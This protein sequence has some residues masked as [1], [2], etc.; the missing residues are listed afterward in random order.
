MYARAMTFRGEVEEHVPLP[1]HLAPSGVSAPVGDGGLDVDRLT[2][3]FGGL[4]ALDEVSLRVAPNEVVGL[5]GPN[6]AGKTTLFN[7]ISGFVRA[8]RGRIS[9]QGRELRGHHPHDLG[10]LG[11]A[12]TLQGV[13]LCRGLTALE[14]VACGAQPALK[15]DFLSAVTG[16][17]RSSAEE[18]RVAA[19][20]ARLL[21]ELGVA[22]WGGRLPGSLPYGIQKRVALARALIGR[23]QLLLLDEPASGLSSDDIDDL[24]SRIRGL[25]ERMSV[26]L[27]EHRMDF[28]MSTCDRIVVLNFGEVIAT[29][30]PDEI[31]ASPE[32]T[33]AY[34]GDPVTTSFHS[35][36]TEGTPDAAG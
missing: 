15:A 4:M 6:G 1:S 19:E 20:A 26:L 11:I 33:A 30:S 12:R 16:I 21:G 17:W 5:I 28:V 32:V 9:W 2:V 22:E 29:G 8:T 24:S 27:V 35:H 34:L 31:Q 10:R 36:P 13:G 7:A 14:N 23:P 3:R 18:R 25:R